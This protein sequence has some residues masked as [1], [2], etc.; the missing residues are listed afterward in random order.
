MY[1]SRTRD[2]TTIVAVTLLGLMSVACH[3]NAVSTSVTPEQE[4]LAAEN[5]WVDV[6]IKGDAD[7]FA[8][9]MS[10]QW[11][12]LT[13]R[14]TYSEKGPWTANIRAGTTQYDAVVLSNQRVRFPRSD[15]AVTTGDFMQKGRTASGDNS[16]EGTYIETWVRTGGRWQVVSSGFGPRPSQQPSQASAPTARGALLR[17][18]AGT[19][20]EFC[21]S[22]GLGVTLKIDSVASGT[23][24]LAMGTATIAAGASNAGTHTDVDEVNYFLSGDGR[25]FVGAD[26]VAV[27]PGL[28]MYVPQ[29]VHHGFISSARQPLV[30]V[31][32]IVPQGLATR[33]RSSGVAPGT[34][35]P[36]GS[37]N[38]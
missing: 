21:R 15:V 38:P 23:Q 14:G 24:R 5:G 1:T 9:Y 4:V 2:I 27:E 18:G 13:H 30:F 16:V 17:P 7:L 12:G 36:A 6:T 19:T 28:T 8:S 26:T 33:F 32:T 22:P 35:P 11:I 10:D 3:R 25:A 29:G 31:W 34:C 37:R 20:L